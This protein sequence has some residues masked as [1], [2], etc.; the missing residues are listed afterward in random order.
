MG[1]KSS[2]PV[3]QA[4]RPIEFTLILET[5]VFLCVGIWRM[6]LK[7]KPEMRIPSQE[8]AALHTSQLHF[9]VTIQTRQ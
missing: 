5:P 2:S 1:I 3:H 8:P 7:R 4:D 6:S 9:H